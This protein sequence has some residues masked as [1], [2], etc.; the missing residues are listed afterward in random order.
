MKKVYVKNMHSN[1]ISN[2]ELANNF[3][4]LKEVNFE[5]F[6]NKEYFTK[7][8]ETLSDLNKINVRLACDEGEK[9]LEKIRV[10]LHLKIEFCFFIKRSYRN[11]RKMGKFYFNFRIS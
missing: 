4:Y 1:A 9:L 10:V 6:N 3:L 7:Y 8:N 11:I 5:N 2:C